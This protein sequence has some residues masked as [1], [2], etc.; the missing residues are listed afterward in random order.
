MG[1]VFPGCIDA[2]VAADAVAHHAAVIEHRWNPRS[3]IVAVVA[4]IA[5][6]HVRAFFSWRLYTVMAGHA[7][8]RNRA[9][10]DKRHDTPCRRYM[11]IRAQAVR[12][13]MIGWP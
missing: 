12:R 13:N 7:G 5:G 2:V 1:R 4:L 10:V 6:C 8:A 11:A 3:R 9:M